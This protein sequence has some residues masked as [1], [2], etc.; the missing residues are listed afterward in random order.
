MPPGPAYN[1]LCVLSSA[2]NILTHAARIRAAQSGVAVTSTRKRR[3]LEV[4][5]EQIAENDR[6]LSSTHVDPETKETSIQK[7]AHLRSANYSA[8]PASTS[9]QPVTKRELPSWLTDEPEVQVHTYPAA[10]ERKLPQP[11]P[12]DK[13]QDYSSVTFDTSLLHKSELDVIEPQEAS[14]YSQD[15]VV[16]Y[17]KYLLTPFLPDC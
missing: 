4:D 10:P 7:D 15:S 12:P 3:K 11:D 2:A 16:Q 13:L 5:A 6:I 17:N 1:F 9:V 14:Y 8:Y